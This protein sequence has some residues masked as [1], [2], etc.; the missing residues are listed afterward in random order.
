[1]YWVSEVVSPVTNK[2]RRNVL[3]SIQELATEG[4]ADAEAWT[5]LATALVKAEAGV[6][7][8]GVPNK[9]AW[10]GAEPGRFF[11]T[12]KGVAVVVDLGSTCTKSGYAGED[13]P[14]FVIPSVRFAEAC[15]L[16]KRANT[17]GSAAALL[18]RRLRGQ[19]RQ[20]RL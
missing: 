19:A 11:A 18:T 4:S 9:H 16:R 10:A 20:A 7:P 3:A 15:L 17:L 5:V 1:M 12:A 14:K 2:L 6:G 8:V 13:C